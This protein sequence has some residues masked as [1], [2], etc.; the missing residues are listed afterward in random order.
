MTT[1]RY[2]LVRGAW[3]AA[4]CV[5]VGH[6]VLAQG[7]FPAREEERILPR[8][9]ELGAQPALI[10]K[11]TGNLASRPVWYLPEGTQFRLLESRVILPR[12][13]RYALGCDEVMG[14]QYLHLEPSE[15]DRVLPAGTTW[16]LVAVRGVHGTK[17]YSGHLLR[18]R[19]TI[20][21]LLESD[22]APSL[23]LE[24][25]PGANCMP[26]VALFSTQFAIELPHGE[27]VPLG[28]ASE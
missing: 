27:T 6:D 13:T 16:R 14:N 10:G 24:I 12:T 4:L 7:Q 18:P 8:L 22:T 3:A 19:H 21:L 1:N 25:C 26:S 20:Y 28:S 2:W 5:G 23:E 11:W 9:T 15:V 17:A